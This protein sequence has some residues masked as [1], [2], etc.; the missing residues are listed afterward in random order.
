MGFLASQWGTAKAALLWRGFPWLDKSAKPE[1]ARQGFD[2]IFVG[3]V[4]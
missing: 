2:E 4:S 3:A 1:G